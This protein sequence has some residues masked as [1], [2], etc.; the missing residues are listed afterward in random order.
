MKTS[1]KGFTLIELMVTVV[2]I[3]IL[4]AIAYPAYQDYVRRG[5][6]SAAQSFMMAVASKQEQYL[7]SNRAYA[8][9]LTD[10][11]A[12]APQETTGKYSFALQ[13]VTATTYEIK[14]TATGPQLPDG[15][16]VLSSSGAKTP[17]DK[18]IR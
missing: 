3:A 10:L 13:N 8:T 11:N 7:L 16:L 1:C 6:R 2:I 4:A 17:T 15:D 9:T 5:N 18:W 12:T 14:A